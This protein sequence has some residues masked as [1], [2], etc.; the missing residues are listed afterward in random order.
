MPHR[1]YRWTWFRNHDG[2]CDYYR[3]TGLEARNHPFT[4]ALVART[5]HT[6]Y[7]DFFEKFPE[8]LDRMMAQAEAT[9][10]A[11]RSSAEDLE[12]IAVR[13]A[14][15]AARLELA[16]GCDYRGPQCGAG[17]DAAWACFARKGNRWGR[18][19]EGLRLP[20]GKGMLTTVSNCLECVT[21][22]APR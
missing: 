3:M 1:L 21:W 7:P 8:E 9:A 12:S 20:D 2:R 5:G 11:P 19:E 22:N 18:D 10:S 6:R 13:A 4:L 16:R 17:C 14:Q 15:G